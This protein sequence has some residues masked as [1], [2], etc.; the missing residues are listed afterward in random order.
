MDICSPL[1]GYHNR[2][3]SRGFNQNLVILSSLLITQN[4][5]TLLLAKSGVASYHLRGYID[6]PM[7]SPQCALQSRVFSVKTP[8]VSPY[9]APGCA[10]LTTS[11]RY[12]P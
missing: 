6:L 1:F 5:L 3:T 10:A 12:Y 2:P 7:S 9:T 8:F 4:G 11:R